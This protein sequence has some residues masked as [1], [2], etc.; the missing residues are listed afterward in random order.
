MDNIG[1]CHLPLAPLRAATDDAS[2][3]VSQ[4]LFGQ[5]FDILETTERWSLIQNHDDGYRGYLSNKQFVIIGTRELAS[6]NANRKI[7]N[8]HGVSVLL[9]DKNISFN[10]PLGSILP[11]QNIF[12]L[13]KNEYRH[14]YIPA[15]TTMLETA[16][17]FLNVPYLWGGKSMFGIDC[18]GFTQTVF[19]AFGIQLPR[20][21]SQQVLEGVPVENLD[22]A[23]PGDLL[24]FDNDKG[25]IIHVGI[26]LDNTHIIHASGCVRIDS[27]DTKG[28]FNND[29]EKYTHHLAGIRH[30][31]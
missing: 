30:M 24:F 18:S 22:N 16:R 6:F 9:A 20:D 2:E 14:S 4:L 25:R 23:L 27:I 13:G 5:S 19:S 28:I 11:E 26:L 21:A 31:Q 8:R 1:I 15:E 3:M 17:T 7:V 12:H 29:L 10:V